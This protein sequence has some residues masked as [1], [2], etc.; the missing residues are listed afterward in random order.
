MQG[1]L[2]SG[3]SEVNI[4]LYGPPGTGKTEFAR[5]KRRLRMAYERA[6]DIVRLALRLQGTWRG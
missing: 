2:R 5:T 6:G 1:A 4:L 3:A